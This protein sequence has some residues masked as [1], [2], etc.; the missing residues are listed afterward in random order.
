MPTCKTTPPPG[1]DIKLY[2]DELKDIVQ[3]LNATNNKDRAIE[4]LDLMIGA[5]KAAVLRTNPTA[6]F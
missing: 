4:R 3:Q 1:Q 6:T 5:I 2:L